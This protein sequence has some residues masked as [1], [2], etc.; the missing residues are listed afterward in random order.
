M[1][2]PPAFAIK[3]L[4]ITQGDVAQLEISLENASTHYTAFQFDLT[5]PA[6]I[7]IKKDGKGKL[8]TK[9]NDDRVNDHQLHVSEILSNTYRF[10]AYS[11]NNA[12]IS[13][14]SGTL[15]TI[16]LNEEA[17]N[18]LGTIEGHI[19]T[20]FLVTANNEMAE[21]GTS[22][23]LIKIVG[24]EYNLAYKVD[25]E[26][27]KSYKIK[28]GAKITPEPAPVKEGY[29]FSGWDNVPETMPAKDVTVSGTFS[30][31]KYKLVYKVDGADYKSSDV[32]YGASITPEASPT[33]EGYSFSGWSD[34][35]NK[36]PAKNV[37]VTGSFKET[38]G[39]ISVINDSHGTHIY[40]MQ[41]RKIDHLQK[42]LNIIRMSDGK[43]K[44][45]IVN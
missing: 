27:Y 19:D 30:I 28:Y 11:M 12:N 36:M 35:P 9:L 1:A 32:E 34:I 13:G 43:T 38:N 3:Q 29:T 23:F 15:L 4:T 5:L 44:K 16:T 24:K 39:I 18:N 20:G 6:G 10:L 21:L 26:D 31:N 33:K 41:G 45:V 42:G 2:Q 17:G 22:E 8:M 14:S 25:S 7:S 37:I 40:D